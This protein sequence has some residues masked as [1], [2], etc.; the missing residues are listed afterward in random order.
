MF[1]QLVLSSTV[2]IIQYKY[3]LKQMRL[4]LSE[5][6]TLLNIIHSQRQGTHERVFS[7]L[8]RVEKSTI[9]SVIIEEMVLEQ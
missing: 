3:M 7:V 5:K 2:Y 8:F 1:V 9:A 6:I 4:L